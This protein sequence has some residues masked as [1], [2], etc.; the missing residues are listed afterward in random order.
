VHTCQ[1]VHLVHWVKLRV[2]QHHHLS[3]VDLCCILVPELEVAAQGKP[4]VTIV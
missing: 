2:C 1:P 3:G 4:D